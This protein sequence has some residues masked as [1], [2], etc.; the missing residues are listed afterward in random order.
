[1]DIGLALGGGGARGMAHL[2]VLKALE[3]NQIKIGALAG[4]SIGGLVGAVYLAGF[5]ADEVIEEFAQVNQPKLYGHQRGEQPSLL[6]L[7]GA[8]RVLDELLGEKTFDDLPIPFA[9]VA[10]DVETGQEIT[11]NDGRLVDAVLATVAVPGIFPARKWGEY[12]LVDGGVSNP[13][14]VSTVR[15]LRPRLPVIGV[16]LTE[17]TPP[18]FVLPVPEIPG[19]APVVEY[20]S[21]MRL[22][23]AMNVFLRSLDVGSRILTEARLELDHPDVLIR[24]KLGEIGLLDKVDVRELAD[25]GYQSA[26]DVLDEMIKLTGAGYRLRRLFS[27]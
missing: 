11:I 6:G 20:I 4:T 1:M 13:V 25:V 3:E 18:N 19:A 12:L 14:P 26:V 7:A 27:R 16:A 24:P 17:R 23:Q 10:V 2:G 15:S 8:T 5:N 21:R 9:V 22:A